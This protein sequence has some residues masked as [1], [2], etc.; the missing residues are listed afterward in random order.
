M[1]KKN[2]IFFIDY[3]CDKLKNKSINRIIRTKLFQYFIFLILDKKKII[4]QNSRVSESY[5]KKKLIYKIYWYFRYRIYF[6]FKYR[7]FSFFWVKT[8]KKYLEIFILNLFGLQILRIFYFE[9]RS[10]LKKIF[11]KNKNFSC[12][13]FLK[14]EIEVLNKDGVIK[15]NHVIT[16]DE[17]LKLIEIFKTNQNKCLILNKKNHNTK[18]LILNNLSNLN[19]EFIHAIELKM[20]KLACDQL[21]IEFINIKPEIS[22]FEDFYEDYKPGISDDQD[23]PH[24]D[25]PYKT[26]KAFL[27]LID[28]DETNGAFAYYKSTQKKIKW[29]RI[30]G[31]YLASLT[32]KNDQEDLKKNYAFKFFSKYKRTNF[33][34]KSRTLIFADTSGYHCRGAFL[35]NKKERII[36]YFNYRYLNQF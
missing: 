28:V 11:N 33:C 8:P 16:E 4:D 1:K 18:K 22:I 31:E 9:I 7:M 23:K 36:L 6:Y 19:I 5:L 15:K 13:F 14:D 27:Y 12:D 21:N 17:R 10:F 20:R 35:E 24:T 2:E 29:N 32:F 25:V 26:F 3:L 30:L 34:E